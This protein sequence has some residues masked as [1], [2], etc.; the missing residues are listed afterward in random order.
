MTRVA[1]IGAG[2]VV[3]TKNLLGD[4]LAFPELHDVE[5][6]LHDIDADRPGSGARRP[7][8]AP[9][10]AA[11]RRSTAPTSCSTWCRSEATRRR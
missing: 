1:F 4:I 9:I 3:F 5:I 10:S 2:S 6:A 7:R 11:A 8:S